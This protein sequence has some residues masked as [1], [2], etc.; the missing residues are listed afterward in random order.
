[1][2]NVE[3]RCSVM[4]MESAELKPHYCLAMGTDWCVAVYCLARRTGTTVGTRKS[5]AEHMRENA[6]GKG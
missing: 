3:V 6:E 1:M 5:V 2:E 4:G